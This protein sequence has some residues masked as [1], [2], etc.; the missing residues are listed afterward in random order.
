MVAATKARPPTTPNTKKRK[1]GE[2]EDEDEDEDEK[3]TNDTAMQ[4]PNVN[5][6]GM[7]QTT[8]ANK[9]PSSVRQSTRLR[10]TR[11]S[12]VGA[13]AG[14]VAGIGVA[15]DEMRMSNVIVSKRL[16]YAEWRAKVLRETAVAL[17]IPENEAIP[18]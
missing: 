9:E 17:G 18:W 11:S 10:T 16:T 5:N 1:A 15:G 7:G 12:G 6:D 8:P 2:N 3:P 13:G 4:S 14:A